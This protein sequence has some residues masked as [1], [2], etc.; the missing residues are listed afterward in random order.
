MCDEFRNSRPFEALPVSFLHVIG[1]ATYQKRTQFGK[2]CGILGEQSVF[3]CVSTLHWQHCC[4]N[5]QSSSVFLVL[6][7]SS[8]RQF[9][10]GSNKAKYRLDCNRSCA[11][12]FVLL[13]V[14][15]SL[16]RNFYILNLNL[17]IYQNRMYI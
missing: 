9:T 7:P 16:H 8:R 5:I 10:F 2:C 1:V 17:S 13:C 14:C 6:F 15:A 12:V 11:R 4:C 3:V